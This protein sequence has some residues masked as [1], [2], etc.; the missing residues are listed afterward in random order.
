MLEYV[1]RAAENGVSS[2]SEDRAPR[3]MVYHDQEA[4]NQYWGQRF[5]FTRRESRALAEDTG[6]SGQAITPQA[7]TANVVEFLLRCERG[8]PS[9][10]YPGANAYGDFQ[11]ASADRA[12]CSRVAG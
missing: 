5:G 2:Q 10:C 12:R 8:W 1:R 9:R 7:W 3:P 4:L 6:G 11:R